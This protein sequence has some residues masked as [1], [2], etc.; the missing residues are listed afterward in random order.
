MD[1]NNITTT[2]T[3]YLESK[4]RQK[5]LIE[6]ITS[7]TCTYCHYGYKL[8]RE[9]EKQYDDIAWVSIHGN[10]DSRQDPYY[11]STC[12][13]IMSMLNTGGFPSAAFNRTF[14]P[15]LA[16]GA[17]L[18]YGLGYDT[19][20]YLKE[21]VSMIREYIDETNIDPSFVALDIEQSYD[22]DSRKLDITVKGTGAA[23][24]AAILEGSAITIY[25]TEEGLKGR[26]YS[27]GSWQNNFVHNNVLR[28]VLTNV[29][30]DPIKWDGDNF[31]YTTSFSIPDDY[32]EENLS[33]TA[34]VAPQVTSSTDIYHMAVN[35][36]EKVAVNTSTTSGIQQIDGAKVLENE[37]YNVDGQRITTPQKGI[38]LI[39]MTDGSFR[40]VV[41][42]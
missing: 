39:K 28:A 41:V 11:F 9:M 1:N 40:K 25:L 13:A 17:E 14:I 22:A 35:N 33:I 42:K 36:C 29:Y 15:G 21:I 26:Q 38:N 18:A 34:F 30:G 27:N 10:L 4:P 23:D 24:A 5:Q 32:K 37:I 3:A 19:D 2:F 31:E 7:W 12:D 8:L 16:E 20:T 6:H